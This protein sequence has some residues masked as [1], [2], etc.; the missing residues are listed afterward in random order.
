MPER[1]R[2]ATA[3][4]C[5][6][7]GWRSTSVLGLNR[8]WQAGLGVLTVPLALPVLFLAWF[9]SFA[10]TPYEMDGPEPADHRAAAV[11]AV[12]AATL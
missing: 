6:R 11:A 2:V 8:M 12:L 10:A 9:S 1:S 7:I 3:R 5:C 4:W